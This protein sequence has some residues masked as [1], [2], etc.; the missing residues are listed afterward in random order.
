MNA[1]GGYLT[2]SISEHLIRSAAIDQTYRIRVF[3]PIRSSKHKEKFPV[4]YAT[5]GDHF[6]G[7]LADIANQLQLMGD[8]PRF[9]VVGIGYENTRA[10]YLLRMR[11]FFPREI[12]LPFHD[13]IASLAE[14]PLIG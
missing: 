8:I 14:A 2:P 12:R 3:Q 4:I 11:D 9:I 13:I 1:A 6:F 10:G 5:D 7:G